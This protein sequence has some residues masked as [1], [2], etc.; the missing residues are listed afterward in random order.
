[1][2]NQTVTTGTPSSPI[3]YD[4]P[5]ISGLLNG[6]TITINGGAVRIDADVRW[7][8]QAAVLGPVTLSSIIGGSF[9]IDGSQIW[10]I[11]FSNSTGNVPTQ[12]NRGTNGVTGV[13][14]GATGELT[15]VWASGSLNPATAGAAMPAT[16]FIKLRSRTGAFQSGETITLPGGA[17]VTASGA[18][19]RS[20][21]HVAGREGQTCT[22]PRLGNFAL[23]GDWYEIGTTNGL[24]DQ[25][26]QFPVA[27]ECPALQVETAPGSGVYEWWLN[28]GRKWV[29]HVQPQSQSVSNMTETVNIATRPAYN[30]PAGF[31]HTARQLR[32]T[33]TTGV[34]TAAASLGA[35][36]TEAGIYRL[37]TYIRKD[38]RRWGFVQVASGASSADRYGAIIDFD[39]AGAVVA[40]PTTG[41]P[42]NTSTTVT[43]V[44]GGWYL[45]E[46]TINVVNVTTSTLV[47][48]VGASNSATPTLVNGQPSYLGVVTE[49]IWYTELQLIA[50][51]SIQHVSSTDERGKFFF[52]NPQTGAIIFAQRAGLTAGLKPASGCKIR[53]PNV[54]LSNAPAI[55]YAINS[56][57]APGLAL[58][59]GFAGSGAFSI[60]HAV[61]NWFNVLTSVFSIT[62]QNAALSA[63]Q[64]SGA[65]STQTYDNWACGI[66][67]D[68]SA[69]GSF[70][71]AT[72]QTGGT[73]SNG[74]VCR[75][76]FQSAPLLLTG[77]ANFTLNNVRVES[78]GINSGRL[79]RFGISPGGLGLTNC[80]DI[81]LEN[82]TVVG[83][84]I[85]VQ[86]GARIEIKGTKYAERIN[87]PTEATDGGSAIVFLVIR[88]NILIDGFSLIPGLTNVHPGAQIVLASVNC[89]NIDIRNIGTPAVP[90]NGGS[91]AQ[92]S[93]AVRFNGGVSDSVVR[94]VYCDNLSS[95]AIVHNASN[96]KIR[97]INVWGDAADGM[98]TVLG[99]DVLAQGCRWS[100]PG[101][102][103]GAV[104]GFHWE[105]AFTGTTSGRLAIFA[106]EPLP[107]TADQCV[108]T[109]GLN[110]N[111]T[112][113]GGAYMPNVGD[114][115]VWTMPYVALG[116]TGVAQFGYGASAAETW[117]LAATN[118]QNF[119]FEYQI[120]KGAG[121][122][123]W[124]SFLDVARRSA[125]G[126]SGTNTIT[127]TAA[128]WDALTHKP[129]VGDYLVMGTGNRLPANTTIT[130]VAGYV[131]TLSA[132]FAS[133][134]GSNE[135]MYFYKDI[136][137]ESISPT[138]GYKLKIKCRANTANA[139]NLLNYLRI[140]FD[141][142]AT[143]QQIQYP[144]PG[145]AVVVNGLVAGSRV[146]VS[147]SDTG[148][149]LAQTLVS[150]TSVS[151]DFQYEGSVVIEARNASA[152]IAYKPWVTQVAISSGT[153]AAVTALQ[154][155]D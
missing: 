102:A 40:T 129:A 138:T 57:Q 8:Q 98:N 137:N 10:E 22:V 150:G 154:E 106:N 80:S 69:S 70:S 151:F 99:L 127:V 153:T 34:H 152:A 60:S 62:M 33:A 136:R 145:S 125:G 87:G 36:A 3:N 42:L 141:T 7:N 32:E 94:R 132:N 24:D 5:S 86:T 20:W 1:M 65:A 74:R 72:A 2:A 85:V 61:I 58:R 95:A 50:P 9:V 31:L 25:V 140:P 18:G 88:Q 114:Q 52:S 38:T 63:W 126:T 55:D 148:A 119:E 134:A 17:T 120:D 76:T 23:T 121:F 146:R 39:A 75:D 116:H 147:R 142:T 11:P 21:I 144:L 4:D 14:S 81:K 84:S 6:E 93:A 12:G 91:S 111:F 112:S 122:S 56:V 30:D 47:G 124:K 97:L 83:T 115:I 46:L 135:L 71:I 118:P 64:V 44:G 66:S 13:A 77:C 128:D 51:S 109:F 27:D 68:H 155:T 53:I 107:T 19:K 139:S 90:L 49:G 26:I 123:A 48:T 143:D 79:G 37:R 117:L 149:V 67:R 108:A 73:I 15:R 96:Q 133:T 105:D 41:T 29:N 110:A 45:V 103:Q 92:M 113:G 54:I 16:G 101:N 78:F 28:A 82:T 59:Y 35:T 104:Y 131:L 43:S 89:S 100:N 130:N